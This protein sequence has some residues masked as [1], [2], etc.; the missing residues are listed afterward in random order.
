MITLELN[1][2]RA[3][4]ATVLACLLII[5]A[6]QLY[7]VYVAMFPPV[8]PCHTDIECETLNPSIWSDKS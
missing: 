8:V 7:Q 2:P 1:P 4:R 5:A 3:Y 6:C